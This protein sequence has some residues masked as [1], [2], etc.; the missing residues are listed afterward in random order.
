MLNHSVYPSHFAP[1]L[2][3]NR[4]WVRQKGVVFQIKLLGRSPGITITARK[5]GTSLGNQPDI[6]HLILTPILQ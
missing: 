2:I 1:I 5:A 4:S 6:S 3:P